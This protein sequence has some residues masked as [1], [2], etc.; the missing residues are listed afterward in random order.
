MS[1][2]ARRRAIAAGVLFVATLMPAPVAAVDP[3]TTTTTLTFTKTVAR[4]DEF[5]QAT[6]T[7]DPV[8]PD[9]PVAIAG[10]IRFMKVLEDNSRVLVLEWNFVD[11]I[12]TRTFG[13]PKEFGTT[14]YVA[15]YDGNFA[16][17]YQPSES[18]VVD[19]TFTQGQ[20]YMEIYPQVATV[21]QHQPLAI[22]IGLQT[23]E[24]TG[25][26]VKVYRVGS[27]T[28]LCDLVRPSDWA[29]S[30]QCVVTTTLPTGVQQF[31]A[32]FSGTAQWLGTQSASK[33]VT[34]TPDIVH[35][36]ISA[37]QFTT[38]YPVTDGYRDTVKFSGI[39]EEDASGTVK[40][41]N[42]SGTLIKTYTI[43]LASGAYSAVWNGRNSAG[44]ILAEGK[45]KIVTT[46]VDVLKASKSATQY[47]TLSKKKL[48]WHSTSITKAGSAYS[49]SGKAGS[50]AV[51]RNT[52]YGWVRLKALNMVYDWAGAAWEFTL[53]SGVAYRSIVVKAYAKHTFIFHY[54]RLGSQNFATC[55]YST[56]VWD[57]SC[58]DSWKGLAGS[59]GTLVW[60]STASL[61]GTHRSGTKLR[62]SVSV[63]GSD[64]YVYK[65]SVSYQYAT[66]GY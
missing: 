59:A 66:L 44:T 33:S 46:L 58:F 29:A 43:A 47:V 61:T 48:I 11:G 53:A 26:T 64:V 63:Q 49:A 36:T 38:F 14:S 35:A 65:A 28:P 51:T 45:Y 60:T 22:D 57:E 2:L 15:A 30:L 27:A 19:M 25:G 52:T 37:P 20:S 34:V 12:G 54:A 24:D 8:P 13:F 31:Y 42:P 21:E 7:I 17:G 18:A 23:D 5:I 1:G 4:L 41:Y 50:G 6:V 32:V 39:R 56:T 40:I 16:Y 10:R 9:P 3:I 55:A 62:S